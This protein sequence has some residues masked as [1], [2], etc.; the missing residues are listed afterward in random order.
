MGTGSTQWFR[1][2]SGVDGRTA[3]A[4]RPEEFVTLRAE[5]AA[6][7]RSLRGT[8]TLRTMEGWLTIQMAGDGRGHV[9][10]AGPLHDRPGSANR[11]VFP[12]RRI[13]PIS[14]TC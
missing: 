2:T 9:E 10:L 7:H 12:W 11:R 4:L 13:S 5:V 6:L 8:A 1:L 14:C 3:G